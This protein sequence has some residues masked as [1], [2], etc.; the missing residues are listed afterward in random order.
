MNE[1]ILSGMFLLAFIAFIVQTRRLAIARAP[2]RVLTRESQPEGEVFLN[3]VVVLTGGNNFVV[4]DNR[5]TEEQPKRIAFTGCEAQR[6]DIALDTKRATARVCC[7]LDG[8][9]FWHTTDSLNGAA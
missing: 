5:G 3:P 7:W 2:R 8:V 6:W 9:E 1:A 4:L